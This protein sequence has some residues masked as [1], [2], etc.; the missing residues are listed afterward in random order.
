MAATQHLTSSPLM[1]TIGAPGPGKVGLMRHDRVDVVL[2]F[3]TLS[4]IGST[5]AAD[6]L[7]YR[8]VLFA[9]DLGP[10]R[11]VGTTASSKAM[12]RWPCI[13]EVGDGLR[14]RIAGTAVFGNLTLSES[15]ISSQGGITRAARWSFGDTTTS[16]LLPLPEVSG[17][18]VGSAVADASG[19]GLAAGALWL[20]DQW[21]MSSQ[22]AFWAN[23]LDASI[24]LQ[25]PYVMESDQR[26][27]SC[28]LPVVDTWFTAVGELDEQSGTALAGACVASLGGGVYAA[29]VGV[30][31]SVD[32][33]VLSVFR[34][35]AGL[36]STWC[37][38]GIGQDSV[39]TEIPMCVMRHGSDLSDDAIL[40]IR[41]ESRNVSALCAMSQDW[42]SHV[43]QNLVDIR[44]VTPCLCD[45]QTSHPPCAWENP[46]TGLSERLANVR[47]SSFLPEDHAVLRSAASAGCVEVRIADG[48][49]TCS[50]RG[51][52]ELH[53]V[54]YIEPGSGRLNP[55]IYDLQSVIGTNSG[56]VASAA[57]RI[58]AQVTPASDGSTAAWMIVGTY[59]SGLLANQSA[60]TAR[61]SF[62]LSRRE[63]E[64]LEWCFTD[65]N[66]VTLSPPGWTIQAV[67]DATPD[68]IA[69][70]V[71]RK[72]QE[73]RL[74]YLTSIADL[75]GDL[76]VDG[77]DIGALLARW[78]L[79]GAGHDETAPIDLDGDGVVNG[80]DLGIM[81]TGW[82]GTGPGARLRVALD[83]DETQ[84]REAIV[85]YPYVQSATELLGFGDLN[86]LGQSLSQ[87]S[88][89]QRETV[90]SCVSLLAS[91]LA[92]ASDD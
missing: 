33:G 5:S 67:H 53:A 70:A 74:C 24:D 47:L 80:A 85:R 42:G 30:E 11:L 17:Q 90:C 88:P 31:V 87:S 51:C 1:R 26:W 48:E 64:N 8:V 43:W 58:V 29:G 59:G 75:N 21:S 35:D 4:V 28:G 77:T 73:R 37:S 69:V 55:V 16:T 60:S 6:I 22:A 54:A 15:G 13:S 39:S 32:R 23:A 19:S 82:T 57:S 83:C 38:G 68:G 40:G 65:A 7:P 89:S 52:N 2:W 12:S 50:S 3:C 72:D 86:D 76:L 91:A 56:E 9:G 36:E 62:W 34:V 44:A 78:G 20:T 81:I 41:G 14:F 92:E 18:V 10:D 45:G 46:D 79:D 61:G 84:W 66:D 63:Q 25:A 49:S 71:A 27:E